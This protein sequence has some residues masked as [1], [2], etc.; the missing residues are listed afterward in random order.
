MTYLTVASKALRDLAPS[1]LSYLILY[2][3]PSFIKFKPRWPPCHYSD[4]SRLFQED[5]NNDSCPSP[6]TH[7][8]S[9]RNPLGF[10]FLLRKMGCSFTL[11]ARLVLNSRPQVIHPPQP[12]KVLG[13]QAQLL[14]S[15]DPLASAYQHFGRPKWE[16]CLSPG[17]RDQ[18]EQHGETPSLLKIQN[19]AGTRL[20]KAQDSWWSD[21]GAPAALP[22]L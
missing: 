4:T 3:S 19:L 12:P 7:L 20:L 16:D 14:D 13:L 8:L 18:P 15:S 1:D 6:T 9:Y 22:G 2:H 17:V 5:L 11:M 10:S 21:S